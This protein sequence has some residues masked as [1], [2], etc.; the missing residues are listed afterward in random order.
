MSINAYK[1]WLEYQKTQNTSNQKI[2]ANDT[3]ENTVEATE[4]ACSDC[5][6][7]GYIADVNDVV[8]PEEVH[9]LCTEVIGD[10]YIVNFNPLNLGTIN[11]G[12]EL[13][14][15][16][17]KVVAV[18]NHSTGVIA[19]VEWESSF[20]PNRVG[21][22]RITGNVIIPEGYECDCPAQATATLKIKAVKK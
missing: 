11:L 8:T 6:T 15:L 13:P 3:I 12:E 17:N 7:S 20:D 9:A 1:R 19:D 4:P 14:E 22:Q 5:A 21:K 2:P 18:T 10:N 16:P